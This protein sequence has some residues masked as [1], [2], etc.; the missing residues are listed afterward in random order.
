MKTQNATFKYFCTYIFSIYFSIS[1]VYGY[2]VGGLT[3]ESLK[4]PLG[5]ETENPLL[6]WTIESGD[7]KD[8]QSAFQ[9][10]VSDNPEEIKKGNGNMWDSG[11]IKSGKTTAS[12]IKENDYKLKPAIFGACDRT[13]NKILL[14]NGVNP[15]FLKWE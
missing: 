14:R 12:N 10:I 9:I 3:C 13:T 8:A 2:K 1:F 15:P 4:N 11:K 6:G 7:K 5:I